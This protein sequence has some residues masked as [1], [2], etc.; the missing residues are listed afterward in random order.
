MHRLFYAKIR[1]NVSVPPE[2]WTSLLILVD[3]HAEERGFSHFEGASASQLL[4]DLRHDSQRP[5][6]HSMTASC[7]NQ[8]YYID[9]CLSSHHPRPLVCMPRENTAVMSLSVRIKVKRPSEDMAA[10][11]YS[12]GRRGILRL[13]ALMSKV[14]LAVGKQ[15]RFLFDNQRSF[16]NYCNKKLPFIVLENRDMLF[17]GVYLQIALASYCFYVSFTKKS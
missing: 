14:S 12:V 13:F 9:L 10:N 16:R 2:H 6:V 3:S 15:S 5:S 7:F 4:G 17:Y 11:R 8:S 1:Q